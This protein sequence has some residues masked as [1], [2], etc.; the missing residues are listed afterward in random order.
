MRRPTSE[1]H[2]TVWLIS[3]SNHYM[4]TE[5]VW[6]RSDAPSSRVC[7]ILLLLLLFLPRRPPF[8]GCGSLR[9]GLEGRA[10]EKGRQ[11]PAER[12]VL[13]PRRPP[14]EEKPI[15]ILPDA[16]P[17]IDTEPI[18]MMMMMMTGWNRETLSSLSYWPLG[19]AD[20]SS[21]ANYYSAGL[22][23]SHRI[24]SAGYAGGR[25]AASSLMPF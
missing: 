12:V 8:P 21:A 15:P 19:L 3:S 25:P 4:N 17:G 22:S 2:L 18:M 24:D 13:D 7:E 23:L 10:S 16:T 9:G 6:N 14:S 11:L 20:S 1:S 5:G